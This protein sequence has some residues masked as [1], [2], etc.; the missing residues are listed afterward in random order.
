MVTEDLPLGGKHTMQYQIVYF[1]MVH[2]KPV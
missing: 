1:S 2:L